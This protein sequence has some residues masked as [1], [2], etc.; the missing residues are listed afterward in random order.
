MAED[1]RQSK[2]AV[3]ST[4]PSTPALAV[5]DEEEQQKGIEGGQAD[6]NKENNA[7]QESPSRLSISVSAT[8]GRRPLEEMAVDGGVVTYCPRYICS[9]LQLSFS[10][11]LVFFS[12]YFPSRLE[13]GATVASL[14]TASIILKNV[15]TKGSTTEESTTPYRL[16]ECY[17]AVSPGRS[18]S[19]DQL[20]SLGLRAGLEEG[21][22]PSIPIRAKGNKRPSSPGKRHQGKVGSP[23]K[24]MANSPGKRSLGNL[25][26]RSLGGQENP[27]SKRARSCATGRRIYSEEDPVEEVEANC[28]EHNTEMTGNLEQTKKTNEEEEA[29]SSAGLTGEGSNNL[30]RDGEETAAILEMVPQDGTD[31]EVMETGADSLKEIERKNED[32]KGQQGPESRSRDTTSR[33]ISRLGR[34]R[35]SVV[36]TES[37]VIEKKRMSKKEVVRRNP[38][39]GRVSPLDMNNEVDPMEEVLPKKKLSNVSSQVSKKV[40]EE[41]SKK[42][43]LVKAGGSKRTMDKAEQ[44]EVSDVPAVEKAKDLDQAITVESGESSVIGVGE[45]E[46]A[47]TSRGRRARAQVSIHLFKVFWWCGFWI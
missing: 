42:V 32:E 17:V 6:V 25:G 9:I 7:E 23:G 33:E 35:N 16:S 28:P 24:R 44:E 38:K 19:L 27:L 40:K 3:F 39:S 34:A 4:A 11:I 10:V 18:M 14:R 45:I 37:P 46:E 29:I 36:Y 5:A 41:T 2:S 30:D 26:K 12:H 1:L 47:S 13:T 22:S 15:G 31:R 20:L 8:P 43:S 21:R